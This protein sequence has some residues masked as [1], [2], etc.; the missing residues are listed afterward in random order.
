MKHARNNINSPKKIK[1][2]GLKISKKK[3]IITKETY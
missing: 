2:L 1:K 3:L